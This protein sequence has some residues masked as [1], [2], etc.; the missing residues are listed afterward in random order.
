MKKNNFVN[1]KSLKLHENLIRSVSDHLEREGYKVTANHIKHPNGSPRNLNGFIPDIRA[2]KNFKE[3]IIEVETCTS[4][5]FQNKLKW[6]RFSFDNRRFWVVVP[7]ECLEVAKMRKE[8]FNIDVEIYCNY[9]NHEFSVALEAAN[10][11]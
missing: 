9:P 11:K 5:L 6:K 8:T 7:P 1:Q 3:I 2:I 4:L 10:S